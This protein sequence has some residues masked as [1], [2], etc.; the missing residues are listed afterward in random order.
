[1]LKTN[2]NRK[3]VFFLL[4]L[5]LFAGVL[6]M[7]YMHLNGV[8]D[9]VWSD[10][11][12]ERPLFLV[13]AVVLV[14]PNIRIAYLKWKATLKVMELGTD[15][16]RT[17]Q[18]FFAGVV[19]G[20][21][22]PNMMGNFIGRFYYFD[23]EQRS[24]ITIL[25]LFSNFAQLLATLLFGVVSA[26]ILGEIYIVGEGTYYI[27]ILIGGTLLAFLGYF[28]S[29]H[30]LNLAKKKLNIYR[31]REILK[32]HP[33]YR[34]LLIGYSMMR[35]AIFTLQFSLVM[36]SFGE[37]YS[38]ELILAIWQ[39]YMIT[40]VIPSLFFGKLGI[41]EFVSI[42]V[43]GALGMNEFS[44]LFTSLIIWFVNSLT[45]ALVGLII[46]KPSKA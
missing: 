36:Y 22:T 20:M 29:D 21:V 32:S 30:V 7:L 42:S 38:W 43:L 37:S 14:F 24:T 13:I 44:I 6:Y 3:I 45:P 11:K 5:T 28:Y 10:F 46:C 41:K 31:S 4:K 8:A 26:L 25:T 40:L 17:M 27:A 2:K 35:F 23:K 18:S 19:M 16:N 9:R 39:V 1:L 34:W 33:K 15:Q 12:F